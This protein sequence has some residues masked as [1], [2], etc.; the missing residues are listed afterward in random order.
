MI[1]KQNASFMREETSVMF[2]VKL[3]QK[4]YSSKREDDFF[5]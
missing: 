2:S 1:A 3:V 5:L 4:R